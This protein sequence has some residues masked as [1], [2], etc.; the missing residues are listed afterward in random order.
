MAPAS[1]IPLNWVPFFSVMMACGNRCPC[2][3]AVSSLLPPVR[4]SP[5]SCTSCTTTSLTP[6][7]FPSLRRLRLRVARHFWCLAPA[8]ACATLRRWRVACAVC[9]VRPPVS[10]TGLPALLAGVR[11]PAQSCPRPDF[12]RPTTAGHRDRRP[13]L[14]A[15]PAPAPACRRLPAHTLPASRGHCSCGPP[16]RGFV[17]LGSPALSCSVASPRPL[18]RPRRRP[19][20]VPVPVSPAAPS[21]R[22]CP[23][24]SLP[25]LPRARA[26]FRLPSRSSSSPAPPRSPFPVARLCPLRGSCPPPPLAA[27]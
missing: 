3:Y 5:D 12:A 10:T 9:G 20:P 23:S 26:S 24:V 11:F 25:P 19:P 8:L 4:P 22:S 21:P 14:P 2:A 1:S 15:S 6:P 16:S 18:S 17:A 27:P 7:V 13:C